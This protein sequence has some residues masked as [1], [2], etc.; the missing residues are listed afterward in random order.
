MISG[1]W[2]ISSSATT[3]NLGDYIVTDVARR[4][5]FQVDAA[6][7]DRT[8]ISGCA[9][10]TCSSVVGSGTNLFA[11]SGLARASTDD[12]NAAIYVTDTLIDSLIR[13]DPNT[14]QRTV[15]SSAAQGTG[16][17][18]ISP[19]SVSVHSSGDLLVLDETLKALIRVDA[20]SGDRTVIAGCV[21]AACSSQV[22]IGTSFAAP[23]D[24]A[25]ELSGDVLVFDSA[26]EAVFRID[27]TSGDRTLLSSALEGSGPDFVSPRNITLEATGHILI[28]DSNT[29][30]GSP[31]LIYRV[32]PL[33]GERTI[34]ASG[35]VGSG[36]DLETPVG[37]TV[38]VNGRIAVLDF[39]AGI[40]LLI[41]PVTGDRT[42]VSS[43]QQGTGLSFSGP[44]SIISVGVIPEPTT[45]LLLGVGLAWLGRSRKNRANTIRPLAAA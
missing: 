45:A 3:L 41:D 27:A 33:T 32:D 5:V 20:V 10:V 25:I 40:I 24:L 6:T 9:D 7:G 15:V 19:V 18:F 38:D 23:H 21:D 34:V 26:L 1:L 14:G 36:R 37:L 12:T 31:G 44:S 35:D 43:S 2:S 11:P 28:S 39:A 22:G 29:T 8:V 30:P 42:I 4:T 13:I 17:A 16:V